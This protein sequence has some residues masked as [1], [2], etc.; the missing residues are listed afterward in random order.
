MRS[1]ILYRIARGACVAALGSVALATL[2]SCD[3]EQ[4]AA[5]PTAPEATAATEQ[6]DA[7]SPEKAKDALLQQM[8]FT[9]GKLASERVADPAMTEPVR[10]MLALTEAYYKSISESAAGTMEKAK[11]SLRIAEITLDL[12]AFAKAEGAYN[13]AQADWDALPEAERSTREARRMQS[14]IFYGKAASLLSR[15]MATDALAWYEKALESDFAIF[16]ELAP[17]DGEKLPE[18]S[19]DPELAR[20]AADAMSSYRCLGECQLWADDPE[21][22]RDTYNKGIDLAKALDKLAPEMSLQYIKLLANLGNLESRVGNKKE[23]LT[24]WVQAINFCQRLYASCPRGDIRLEARR[25]F[26]SLRPHV[27]TLA[28]EQQDANAEK[29]ENQTIQDAAAPAATPEEPTPVPA[30]AQ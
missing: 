23:A 15:R 25:C 30:P 4:P 3:E 1:Q 18:G 11:L 24:A 27:L 13:T 17:A 12:T 14:A 9:I 29:L 19:V 10:E 7:I 2:S 20:A 28:R 26:E 5:T 22:A 8:V 16:K 6:A 21:E